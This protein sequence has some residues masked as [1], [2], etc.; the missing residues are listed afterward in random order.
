[1][2][3]DGIARLVHAIR[4]LAAVVQQAEPGD[5]AEIHRRLGLRLTYNPGNAKCRPRSI[6]ASTPE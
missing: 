3:R 2:S 4:D 5:K 1:M 6:P